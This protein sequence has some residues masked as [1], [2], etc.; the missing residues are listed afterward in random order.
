MRCHNR[1]SAGACSTVERNRFARYRRP[2]RGAAPCVRPHASCVPAVPPSATRVDRRV[3]PLPRLKPPMLHNLTKALSFNI[4]TCATRS[5]RSAQRYIEYIDESTT[6]APDPDLTDV[7]EI[8]APT[9]NVRARLRSAG[10]RSPSSSPSAVIDR[11]DA[12][13]VLSAAMREHTGETT[14]W[15]PRQEHITCT[16][17]RTAPAERHRDLRADIDVA[18]AAYLAAEGVELPDRELRVRHRGDDYRVR[19]FTRDVKAAS[20]TSTTAINSIQAS[21]PSHQDQVRDVRR[22]R[23][24]ENIFTPRCT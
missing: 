20:T 1:S 19:G 9:P 17:L 21:W 15:P 23:L 7:A 6:R 3:Q 2:R 12:Q 22:E 4:S 5:P 18:P 24:Q 11:K 13:E 8:S 10:A 14:C 16:P